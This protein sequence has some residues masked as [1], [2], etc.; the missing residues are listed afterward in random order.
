M[1]VT[2]VWQKPNQIPEKYFELKEERKKYLDESYLLIKDGYFYRPNACGYTL[3]ILEA[4]LYPEEEAKKIE[5]NT[6]REVEAV[7]LSKYRKDR[8]L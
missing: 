8:G 2:L 6:H 4:G 1:W 3:N 5:T 7:K